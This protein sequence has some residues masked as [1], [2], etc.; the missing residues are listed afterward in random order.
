MEA[1]FNYDG[2][3]IA[4]MPVAEAG[5]TFVKP[6]GWSTGTYFTGQNAM[7]RLP[8]ISLNTFGTTWGPGSDPWTNGAEDYNE[9]VSLSVTKAQHQLKFGGGYN[10]YT[11]NQ[12]NGPALKETTPSVTAGA[13]PPTRPRAS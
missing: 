3:K 4:I 11:K 2:N 8:D 6:S 13:R 10:R 5:G 1:A 12:I 7:N 9:I